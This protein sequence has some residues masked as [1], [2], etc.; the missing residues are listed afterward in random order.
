MMQKHLVKIEYC[1]LDD[2]RIYLDIMVE[3]IIKMNDWEVIIVR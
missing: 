2:Y 1:N 3:L